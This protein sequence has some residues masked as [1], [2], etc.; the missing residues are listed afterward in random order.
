[1][2]SKRSPT[3]TATI[4]AKVQPHGERRQA[5]GTSVTLPRRSPPGF[6][7]RIGTLSWEG[8]EPWVQSPDEL[9]TSLAAS[10]D[11][12]GICDLIVTAGLTAYE[13][14]S[15]EAVLAASRGTPVLFEA[16]TEGGDYAWL[17]VQHRER[18]PAQTVLRERQLLYRSG[19]EADMTRLAG[20]VASGA[21]VIDF[22][23]T[24]L[25][26]VLF[27]CGENNLLQPDAGPSVLRAAPGGD[28]GAGLEEV[29]GRTWAVLNPAHKPYLKQQIKTS[30]FGK[31]AQGINSAGTFGPTLKRLV[32]GRRHFRDGTT[33]SVALLHVNN[34][35]PRHPKT[36]PYSSV[37]F[38][39]TTQRMSH[40]GTT[41]TGEVAR[42][43]PG[44]TRQWRADVYEVQSGGR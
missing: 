5:E 36:V 3:V 31:I 28:E 41:A 43:E 33:A 26:F 11:S 23:G 42:E 22:V 8:E 37:C 27:I 24:D 18:G 44:R 15:A 35:S 32:V 7:L 39:D 9:L 20:V 29:V 12:R 6:P 1:M 17:L 10:A 34:F 40:V 30:G 4:R 21:G 38:G 16:E 14:P 19:Q 2:S 25:C 13:A